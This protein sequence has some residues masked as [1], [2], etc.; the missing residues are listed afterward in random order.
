MRINNNIPALQ[1]YTNL[2]SVNANID[3]SM[4]RLSSGHKINNVNDDPAG[5]AISNKLRCQIRGIDMADRNA[6]DAI[7]V[8]QT[9]EGSLQEVHNMLHRMKELA[10]QASSGTN[11]PEDR[12]K[13]Q[14]EL[15]LLLSEIDDTAFKTDFNGIKLLSGNAARLSEIPKADKK[16]IACTYIS[17]N[18]AP[19]Q[20][21]YDIVSVGMPAAV[22][23]TAANI[24]GGLNG[25]LKINGETIVFTGNE[26]KEEALEMFK[27]LYE[28]SNI[29]MSIEDNGSWDA[30]ANGS[31]RIMLYTKDSGSSESIKIDGDANILTA[32]GLTKG[33][34]KG[35]DAVVT[36]AELD[37][38]PVNVITNGNKIQLTASNSRKIE[39]ELKLRNAPESDFVWKM[40][41]GTVASDFPKPDKTVDITDFGTLKIQIGTDQYMEME[42]QIPEVTSK[43]LGIENINISSVQGAQKALGLL[44]KAVGKLSEIRAKLGAYQNRLEYTSRSLNIA[45]ENTSESRSRIFDAD[46]ALEMSNLTQNNI[47]SQA[48]MAILAQANQRPQQLL[49]LLN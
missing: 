27:E 12:K 33:E 13:M 5:M 46:M 31:K 3:K 9:A 41:D 35:E 6:M 2:L 15:S 34:T 29:E 24:A 22:T 14:D 43:S 40:K 49:Q 39:L 19:G 10:V 45:S 16:S 42:V 4:K 36:N 48:G 26:S 17:E 37:G 30:Y 11:T 25:E 21:K 28:R 44:D 20:L 38:Q 8:I 23:S 1:A 32:F 7:S 18:V 47:I